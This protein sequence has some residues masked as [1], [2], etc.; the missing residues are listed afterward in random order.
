M[1]FCQ[2]CGTKQDSAF[3]VKCKKCG[4]PLIKIEI[5]QNKFT[6]SSLTPEMGDSRR[7]RKPTN[8]VGEDETDASSVPKLDAIE[9]D[10]EHEVRNTNKVKLGEI[11]NN[12]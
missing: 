10:V 9:C 3:A 5:A 8:L 6:P 1:K 4:K 7:T 2:H 12:G 11:L